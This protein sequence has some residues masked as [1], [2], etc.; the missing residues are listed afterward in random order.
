MI[1]DTPSSSPARICTRGGTSRLA[2]LMLALALIPCSAA[3]ADRTIQERRPADPRGAVE[4]LDLQG[5]IELSGWNRPEVEVTGT[6]SSDAARIE[7]TTSGDHTRI[8]VTPQ[9]GSMSD[10]DDLKLVIHVPA[11]SSVSATLVNA[12]LTVSGITGD[13]NLHTIGGNLSGTVGGN[14]RAN[15]VNGA[16]R[17]SAREGRDVEVKTINGDVDLEAGSGE[18]EVATVSGDV[19]VALASLE[20]GR[21]KSISGKLSVQ[22][23]LAPDAE[24][25][26]QSVSGSIHLDFPAAPQADFDVQT[27]GGRIDSCFGPAPTESHY[28]PG[29]RLAFKSGDTHARV[30]IDTKSGDVSLCAAGLKHEHASAEPA[31][32]SEP[33][34]RGKQVARSSTTRLSMLYII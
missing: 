7:V 3:L 26:A 25:D 34:P 18:V 11:A 15:T 30:R 5:T 27:F 4:I 32:L 24:L 10:R 29:S 31:P 33:A 2:P 13:A 21:F 8:R 23:A 17:M 28:G 19:K 14:L 22:L 12:S 6:S 1:T 9:L 20:R 16:V